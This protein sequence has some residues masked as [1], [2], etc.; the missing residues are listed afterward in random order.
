[1]CAK[2]VALIHR[3]LAITQ[4]PPKNYDS[5]SRPTGDLGASLGSCIAFVILFFATDNHDVFAFR[6][7]RGTTIRHPVSSVIAQLW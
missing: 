4:S 5:N 6:L 7:L 3:T 1:M 2:H